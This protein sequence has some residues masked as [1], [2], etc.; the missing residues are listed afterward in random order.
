VFDLFVVQ[1]LA[2]KEELY[3]FIIY[4]WLIVKAWV[5]IATQKFVC[6]Q[7]ISKLEECF[8]GKIVVRN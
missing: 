5:I 7:I 4:E 3:L 2:E 8:F 6:K 1:K